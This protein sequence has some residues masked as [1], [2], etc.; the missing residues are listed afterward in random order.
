MRAT[1][2]HDEEQKMRQMAS[3]MKKDWDE[4]A[5]LN[6]RYYIATSCEDSEDAFRASGER[7]VMFFFTGLEH[8]LTTERVLLDIGCGIGRMD[9]AIASRVG[10]IIGLDVS[11]EMVR[12]ARERLAHVPNVDFVEGNGVDLD[13]I[14]DASIDLIFS[15]IVFQHMPKAATA[16]Y[17]IDA[18]RVLKRDGWLVFQVPESGETALAEPP[19]ADTFE[20]RFYSASSLQQHM[21]RL[22][23]ADIVF[24]RHWVE[25]PDGGFNHLRT[26]CRWPGD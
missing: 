23:Y 20:L 14:D 11:A 12:L 19:D 18:R 15:H 10:R 9:E 16:N 4:R 3:R 2:M 24:A 17:L 25:T 7:D 8:L 6:A 26:C 21:E 5:T 13:V 1:A 22:G